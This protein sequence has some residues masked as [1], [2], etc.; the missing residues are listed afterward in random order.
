MILDY[1]PHTGNYALYVPRGEGDPA[2]M[3]REYGL[4]F[5]HPR[6]NYKEA[7]LFTKEPYAAASFWQHATPR[8]RQHLG[9][10]VDQIE[11]SWKADSGRH[12]DVPA[13][14]ELW[15]YQ[16]AGV[17][18]ALNRPHA[19]IGD[20]MGLGKTMQAI[21]LA[22]EMQAKRV[23]VVCPAVIR[24]QW[25]DRIREW[26][27]MKARGH[28]GPGYP[29]P[30]TTV[31]PIITSQRGVHDDAAWTVVSWDLIRHP[32]LWRALA[33]TEYDLLI[34]DEA[35]YAKTHNA[36]RTRALFGGGREYI[37][38]PLISRAKK[39]VAL[40]GT[41]L[42]NRPR[43]AYTLARALC[44]ESIDFASEDDF[45]ERYN[46][47][48]QG[49]SL[50]GKV[51]VDEREGRL[52]ELQNRLRANFMVRRL[53][54]DVLPQLKRPL[55]DL[56]R[57]EETAA[58]K[59]ALQAESLLDIDPEDLTGADAKVL[60]QIA[61]ARRL[62]GVAL[63]PQIVQWV[64]M[65][66]D[67]GAGKLVLFAWH[68]EV[69]DILCGGLSEHGIVRVDG[70][71]SARSKHAK[72]QKFIADP[73]V[74]VIVGNVLSLG[75][76]TDGLQHVSTHV[77]LAEP[78]WVFG[79]NEQCIKRLHRAGQEGQVS[80]DIFVAPGSLSEKVLAA[81]LRKGNIVYRALDR[82]VA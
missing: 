41:P 10:I 42:P 47:R 14:K 77:L 16:R 36:K 46:P 8:A 31:Y 25:C 11:A 39:T 53:E 61:T 62:M 1:I 51:W 70:G 2:V 34:L 60:G 55:Y 81:A 18:Y 29:V 48:S 15:P 67:G 64:K 44:W 76:G 54:A 80:A 65:L 13:D 30:N 19:L 26:S 82:R 27:T 57:V 17:D 50:S 37:A 45:N 12:I 40:T 24:F 72:V 49:R 71:D 23:L 58:V 35:H 4:D 3:M 59:A 38:E 73:A 20:D 66:L 79:N 52:P 75:T 69:L 28:K 43:E 6:S 63:A 68:K 9:H 56:I 21:A 78:D 7:C 22:N 32:A 74:Q 33:K 5:S